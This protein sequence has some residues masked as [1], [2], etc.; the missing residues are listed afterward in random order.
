MKKNN[1]LHLF[2][3]LEKMKEYLY[4]NLDTQEITDLRTNKVLRQSIKHTRLYYKRVRF[5]I[6]NKSYR[7]RVHR[8]FFYWH[9]GY[10]PEIVDHIDKNSLNNNIENLREI[11]R[12]GNRRNSYKT[13]NC[14]S[15]Y[16]G[17]FWSKVSKKW[18]AQ[19]FTNKKT[20]YL[21]LFSNED[22]AGQAV[23]DK[24]RELGLE[25]ISV[26]NDTPQERA[27]KNIQFDPLPQEMNHIKDL[28]L[29][30]EPLV[31]FK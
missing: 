1:I 6:N 30:I 5:A 21:G 10:L 8:L 25:E 13:K 7:L 22:D 9:Y 11:N 18:S 14:T 17:V 16:K 12:N 29:N 28:F 27:R 3:T 4:I 23:N 31:D 2:P 24:I 26:M 15:K 20:I 19:V